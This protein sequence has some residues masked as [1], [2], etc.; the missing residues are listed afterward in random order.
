MLNENQLEQLCLAWFEETG[1]EVIK[2]RKYH[3]RAIETAQ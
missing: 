3:N 2:L 1:Y